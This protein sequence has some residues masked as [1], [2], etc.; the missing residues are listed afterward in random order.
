MRHPIYFLLALSTITACTIQTTDGTRRDAPS[1]SPTSS[2]SAESETKTDA[3]NAVDTCAANGGELLA[4]GFCFKNCTYD[5][6]KP[7]GDLFGDCTALKG[8]CMKDATTLKSSPGYCKP[9]AWNGECI[10]DASCGPGGK[11]V[12]STGSVSGTHSFCQIA[13]DNGTEC[14][15]LR[16][17][18]SC[19]SGYYQDVRFCAGNFG[20][21]PNASEPSLCNAQ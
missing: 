6:A 15:S 16:C 18:T 17:V 12:T 20:W 1:S 9:A 8:I 4:D 19:A 10:S 2:S 11:C 13:C 14:G 7:G 3:A 5:E 21:P